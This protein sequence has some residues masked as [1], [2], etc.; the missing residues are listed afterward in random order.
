MEIGSKGKKINI[1]NDKFTLL[2]F[3]SPNQKRTMQIYPQIKR[4]NAVWSSSHQTAIVIIVK[5]AVH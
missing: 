2:V 3:I 4:K 1:I 5:P